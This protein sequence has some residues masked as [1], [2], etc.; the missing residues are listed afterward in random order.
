M[1]SNRLDYVHVAP[2]VFRAMNALDVQSRKSGIEPALIELVRMR[3]SQINGC[4]YC[5]DT[6]S[7]DA[8]AAGE[9]AQRLFVLEAWREAPFFSDRERAALA[10][11]E[12]LTLIADGHAPDAVFEE[13]R[14]QF[15]ERELVELTLAIVAINSWNR[16]SIGF[17]TVPELAQSA[18]GIRASTGSR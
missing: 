7:R 4:A 3:C 17:R 6:H 15:S 13:A 11:A 12:A 9:N 18:T 1:T 5:L 10:W 2:E 8:L 16:F 14:K